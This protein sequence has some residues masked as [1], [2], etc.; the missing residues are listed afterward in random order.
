LIKRASLSLAC[1]CKSV[2]IIP[3]TYLEKA[4]PG[5]EVLG[6]AIH[7]NSFTLYATGC[8]ANTRR[9]LLTAC[10]FL[11]VACYQRQMRRKRRNCRFCPRAVGYAQPERLTPIDESCRTEPGSRVSK[12]R[13]TPKPQTA[14]GRT[15]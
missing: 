12:T 14:A 13:T 6:P 3:F 8:S 9:K 1:N 15:N 7:V 10:S 4:G 2:N 11:A 5:S